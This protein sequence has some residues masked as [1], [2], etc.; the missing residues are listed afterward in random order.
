MHFL[1]LLRDTVSKEEIWFG[2]KNCFNRSSTFSVLHEK[3][4]QYFLVCI[5][6]VIVAVYLYLFEHAMVYFVHIFSICGNSFNLALDILAIIIFAYSFVTLFLRCCCYFFL[7]EYSFYSSDC[8]FINVA[9]ACAVCICSLAWNCLS[10]K[11]RLS[12]A[13]YKYMNAHTD[14]KK[15]KNTTR[16][17]PPGKQWSSGTVGEREA[18]WCISLNGI[19]AQV[20]FIEL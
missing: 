8:T 1:E 3:S 5:I 13:C 10:V 7:T 15:M 16:T 17:H 14:K 12:G 4:A 2:C 18:I 19:N 6:N 20:A 11:T 9:I